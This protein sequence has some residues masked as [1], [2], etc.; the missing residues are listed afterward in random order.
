MVWCPFSDFTFY[1][2]IWQ[3]D[4]GYCTG[5]PGPDEFSKIALERAGC[6]HQ[7]RNTLEGVDREWPMNCTKYKSP[8]EPGFY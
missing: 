7:G 5:L 3:G 1:H 2:I 4:R 6:L 8:A